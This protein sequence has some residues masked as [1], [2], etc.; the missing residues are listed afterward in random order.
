MKRFCKRKRKGRGEVRIGV[1][2]DTG[3]IRKQL[4]EGPFNP[5]LKQSM[6][7]RCMCGGATPR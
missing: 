4:V 1:K 3:E 7:R 5:I 6:I 2:L